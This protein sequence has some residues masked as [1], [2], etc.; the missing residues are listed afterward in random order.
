MTDEA[1]SSSDGR[2]SANQKGSQR[3]IRISSESLG[4]LRAA[5][6]R[7]AARNNP[8]FEASGRQAAVS[9]GHLVAAQVVASME[10]LRAAAVAWRR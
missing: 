2:D 7:A 9:I 3:P 8:A 5:I 1:N 6:A 10:R 4:L